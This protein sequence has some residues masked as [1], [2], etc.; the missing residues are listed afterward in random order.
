[1]LARLAVASSFVVAAHAFGAQSLGP[2]VCTPEVCG[3]S[4]PEPP[5]PLQCADAEAQAP[6]DLSTG[7]Q[8][9][10]SAK[11][12][13][14]SVA[15]AARLPQTNIHFHLGAEH[16]SDFYYDT[17]DSDAYDAD[18][19][20]R[21]L[22]EGSVRPG[23][24]CPA[25]DLTEDQLEPYDWKYCK[26]EMH[27]GKSYEVHYVHSSAGNSEFSD[28]TD[29]LGSAAGGRGLANPMLVVQ[30]QIFQIV[31]D[32][33]PEHMDSDLVHG[34]DHT[35]HVDA[36]MY[37]GS[38][39]G[40]SNNNEVCSPYVVSWHVDIHCHQ[41]SAAAFDNMCRMMGENYGLAA[42]THPH[43]SRVPVDESLV[44]PADEVYPLV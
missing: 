41:I 10:R 19:H 14:L 21:L 1:M 44:V 18:N 9:S 15:Q 40:G 43:S 32:D 33:L 34:W 11:A 7:A 31:N 16:K 28:L 12:A 42:D 39:T 20:R 37:S 4:P 17:S 2:D 30:A 6:R 29:G 23:N 13:V 22:A 5:V 36:V 25:D 8:G 38:T 35:E 3:C 26:G 27:V 24:M